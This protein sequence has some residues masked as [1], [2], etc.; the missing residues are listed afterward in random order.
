MVQETDKAGASQKPEEPVVTG[1]L[2]EEVE[3]IKEATGR[4]PLKM[5]LE[6]RAG[7]HSELLSIEDLR[8]GVSSGIT[9]KHIKY[10]QTHIH[11]NLPLY[12]I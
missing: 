8:S 12:I 5:W 2:L 7:D 10:V 1:I 11:T 3:F 6:G 9:Y 4:F